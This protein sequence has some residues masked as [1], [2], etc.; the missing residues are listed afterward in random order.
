MKP[1]KR[2]AGAKAL[3]SGYKKIEKK[4]YQ[5]CAQTRGMALLSDFRA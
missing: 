4:R 2:K 5:K 3:G 1:P